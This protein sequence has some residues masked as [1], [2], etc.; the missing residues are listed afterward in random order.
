MLL[1][2]QRVGAIIHC[3]TVFAV[4]R[5]TLEGYETR[6]EK[7]TDFGDR[8]RYFCKIQKSNLSVLQ[9]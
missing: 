2:G 7:Q 4:V 1:T 6:N 8:I 3:I 9:V 5:P